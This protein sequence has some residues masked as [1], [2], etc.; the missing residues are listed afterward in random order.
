[1]NQG[2]VAALP[3]VALHYV[4]DIMVAL[5]RYINGPCSSGGAIGDG[6]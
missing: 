3:D 5:E 6:A 1:M 2:A 4:H